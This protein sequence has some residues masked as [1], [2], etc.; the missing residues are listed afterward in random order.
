MTRI[1]STLHEGQDTL[2]VYV[3]QFFLE[4][5]MFQTKVVDKIKIHILCSI[6]YFYKIMP[7]MRDNVEKI[8]YQATRQYGMAEAHFMLD[9]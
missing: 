7:F 2:S 8:L 9:N 1:T 6:T 3:A 5:E 4:G